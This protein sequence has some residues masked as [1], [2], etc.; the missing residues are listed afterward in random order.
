MSEVTAPRR[1]WTAA[2]DF[3]QWLP[4]LLAPVVALLIAALIYSA[5][6]GRNQS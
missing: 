1:S 4:R 6:R 2:L 5:A 3:R